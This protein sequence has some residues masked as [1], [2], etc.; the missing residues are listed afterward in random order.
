M[1]GYVLVVGGGLL[2]P[3]GAF[4]GLFGL[5]RPFAGINLALC[6]ASLVALLLLAAELAYL[7][8]LLGKRFEEMDVAAEL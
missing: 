6:P 1:F 7:V 5:L 3:A 2:L 4:L 8:F